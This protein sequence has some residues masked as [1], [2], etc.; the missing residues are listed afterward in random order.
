MAR[1]ANVNIPHKKRVIIALTYV[2]GIGSTFASKICAEANIPLAKRVHELSEDEL[3]RLRQL[4]ESQYKVEGEL[5]REVSMNIKKK[6]DIKCYQGLR[7]LRKLPVRGQNTKSN[8]RT[9]KGRAVAIAGKK[10]A[11]AKK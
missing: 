5:R 1:I 9:W 6:K 4:I 3:S 2:Y 11:S 8:A 7:H 10:K